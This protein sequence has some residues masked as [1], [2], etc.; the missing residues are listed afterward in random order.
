M[1]VSS[2]GDDPFMNTAIDTAL[3]GWLLDVYADARRKRGVVWLL[4]DDDARYQTTP[5]SDR[6]ILRHWPPPALTC[7]VTIQT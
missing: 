2:F 5:C 3:T 6:D 7:L 4:A 1:A